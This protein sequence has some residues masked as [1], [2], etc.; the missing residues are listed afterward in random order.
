MLGKL[1]G[2]FALMLDVPPSSRASSLPHLFSGVHRFSVHRQSPCGS[3]LAR[4]S[5]GSV[6]TDV[7]CAAAFAGKLAPTFVLGRSQIQ[8]PPPIPCGSELARNS[9]GSVC[10]DVECAAAFAG[11][12]APTFV[13]GRSQIQCPPPIPL[14]ERACSRKRWDSLHR[15]RMYLRHREQARSYICSRLGLAGRVVGQDPSHRL[16]HGHAAVSRIG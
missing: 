8:C 12:L 9:G 14:W 7:E 13:L 2:Q 4:D 10:I 6:C 11:K 3:E 15:C 1:V 16:T 5:G